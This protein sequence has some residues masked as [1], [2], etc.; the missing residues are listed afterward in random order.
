MTTLFRTSLAAGLLFTTLFTARAQAVPNGD[1]ETWAVRDGVDTPVDWLTTD[2]ILRAERFAQELLPTGTFTK[3]TDAHG[4]TYALRLESKATPR[5]V[6]L[7][8]VG[9]GKRLPSN[10]ELG[11]GLPFTARPAVLQFYY[12]L[13]GPQ[14]PVADEVPAAAIEL[15]RTVNGQVE[16]IAFSYLQLPTPTDTYMLAQIPIEY[17][18]AATPDSV[19]LAFVTNGDSD[20]FGNGVAGTVLQIDDISFTGTATATRDAK[21]AAAISVWPN[22]SPDGRYVLGATEPALL[23]A[24]LTVLDATGRIVRREAAPGRSAAPTRALDLSGL[25]AGIYTLQLATPR[26]LVTRKLVR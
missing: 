24:P 1:F 3:T 2:D 6:A 7:A 18:S 12:K 5:G 23:A 19:H 13:S 16:T 26:G 10:S 20:L 22:P 4:G 21:L 9:L 15:T 17:E 25:P 14:S 8:I 11:A